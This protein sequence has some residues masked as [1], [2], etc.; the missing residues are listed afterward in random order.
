MST[1]RAEGRTASAEA[2]LPSPP[3]GGAAKAVTDDA[4][5]V[6]AGDVGAGDVGLRVLLLEDSALDA[7]LELRALARHRVPVREAVVCARRPQYEARLQ[8]FEPDVILSDYLLPDMTG[9]EALQLAL[10]HRPRTPFVIVSGVVG[11][12]RA[13]DLLKQGAWDYVLKDRLGRLAPAVMEALQRAQLERERQEALAELARSEERLRSIVDTVQDGLSVFESVRDDAGDIVD[14]VWTHANQTAALILQRVLAEVVGARL[15]DVLP[16]LR[17]SALF[18]DYVR[19]VETGLPMSY[20]ADIDDAV[21]RGTFEGLAAKLGDGFVVTYRDVTASRQAAEAVAASEQRLRAAIDSL[22]DPCALLEVVRDDRGVIIDFRYAYP[23][24]AACRYDGLSRQELTGRQV[25]ELLPGRAESG[26]LAMYAH[27]VETGE[28][29]VLDGF[30]YRHELRGG[31]P[32]QYDIRAARVGDG[33][34]Y[35]WRDVT[36]RRAAE[37]ALRESEDRFRSMVV[38]LGEGLVVQEGDGRIVECNPAAERILGLPRRV[39][40]GLTWDDERLTAVHEDGTVFPLDTHP[41]AISLRTGESC[42]DVM[43]GVCRPGAQPRW[44]LVNAVPLLHQGERTPYAT[45]TSFTDITDLR[46]TV[47]EL[48][49]SEERFRLAFDD[50]L[51][52]M[53]LID[54]DPA[55]AGR[56]ARVNPALCDFLGRPEEELLGRSFEEVTYPED[57]ELTRASFAELVA[58]EV[59]S[60]RAERRYRHVSGTTLWGL[61]SVAMIRGRDGGSLY[62]LAQ[63]EDVTARKRAETN[64]VFRALHDDL[65]GLPNRALLLNHLEGALARAQRTGARVGVLFIDLDNFK[66]INDSYGHLVGD[67][68]LKRVGERISRSM[69]GGDTAARIGGDEFVVLC[70]SLAEAAD[71]GVV[72]KRIQDELAV[73]IPM[74]GQALSVTASIGIAI[75]DDSSTPGTLLR[76]ADSAMYVAKRRGGRRWEPANASLHA[77]ALRVLTLGGELREALARRQFRVHYQPIYDLRTYHI[78]ATEALV[79][80]QHPRRGLLLPGEFLDVAE[81]RG[82]ISDIGALVLR[83]A[84]E[85]AARWTERFGRRAPTVAVNVASP[86]LGNGGL[87]QLIEELLATSGLPPAQLCLEI[88]ESQLVNVGTSAVT[89][90]CRVSDAGVRI[91]VDDFGTGFAG[92]EYLRR[93]P[94]HELK[95]DISFVSGLNVDPTDT[96]ITTSVIALGQSLGLIVVAEGIERQ[97]QLDTLHRLGCPRGQG[98]L[99]SRAVPSAEIDRLVRGDPDR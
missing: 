78:V 60:Y 56:F 34:C 51:A 91:A 39:L 73:E 8:D 80:W 99:W 26:L 83:T 40:L 33:V 93:L 29:L 3:P 9:E 49:D 42:R 96:A 95:V 32:R 31:E 90:L 4:P 59:T 46:R 23:N 92:F 21:M 36:D 65:T 86:Q 5:D 69:R 18:A 81:Q 37:L 87:S 97:D 27:V 25:L 2:A 84:S 55:S 15:L 30:T 53:A 11:E 74:Q 45:V 75:S 16:S 68:F 52:G 6:G 71:A 13:V 50:A 63:I 79:R 35:T 89:D 77:A 67:E 22:L 20:V 14:F 24:E 48:E 17:D 54:V 1:G 70:E 76:D 85:Q 82:V 38:A 66:A 47:Q 19:V 98:W 44:I 28:P 64:L 61:L 41:A 10:R 43:M 57:V 94:V 88:T 58:G 12:E 62:A 72:A 7:G